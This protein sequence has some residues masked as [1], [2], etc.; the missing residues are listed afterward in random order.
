M[1][2]GQFSVEYLLVVGF[3]LIIILPIMFYGYTTF[4]ESRKEVAFASAN[5]IGYDI[6]NHAKSIYYLGNLSRITL[7]LNFPEGIDDIDI[8]EDQNKDTFFFISVYGSELLFKSDV[9]ING[10]FIEDEGHYAPGLKQVLIESKGD[11][12]NITFI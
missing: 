12:V 1:K 5:K 3:A 4:Q 8:L 10:S 6:T 11:F 7:E 9:H 2:R